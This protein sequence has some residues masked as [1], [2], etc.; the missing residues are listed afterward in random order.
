METDLL[1]CGFQFLLFP[2]LS[3]SSL[4]VLR[5][6][7]NK[8]RT[9]SPRAPS[10]TAA[11]CFSLLADLDLSD[12]KLTEVP[13]SLFTACPNLT[14]VSFARNEIRELP[15]EKRQGTSA[16]RDGHNQAGGGIATTTWPAHLISLDVSH[17][18]LKKLPASMGGAAHSL[19]HLDVSR[20]NISSVP[21]SC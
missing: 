13:A 11:P 9:F 7:G 16:K 1:L 6:R 15:S 17:N 12:N 19:T 14:H 10:H 4:L 2:P 5:L 21:A 18:R 8:L 20:N 3:T